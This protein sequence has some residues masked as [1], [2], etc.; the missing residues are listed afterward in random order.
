MPSLPGLDWTGLRARFDTRALQAY[1]LAA[2]APAAPVQQAWPALHAWCLAAPALRFALAV[3]ALH[4]AAE[5]PAR[6]R[7]LALQ[8]DGSHALRACSSAAARWR[9]RLRVKWQDLQGG[10]E[11]AGLVPVLP[12]SRIWDSG[13]ARGDA[14]ALAA[15]LPRRPSFVVVDEGP[16]QAMLQALAGLQARAAGFRHP[17]RVL[18]LLP[19]P[20]PP[21]AVLVAGC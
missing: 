19:G 3:P 8:L 13:R 2:N 7:S 20:V 1:V 10:D 14:L 6:A 12:A 17:V 15:L 5:A 4:A 11:A 16:P 9:L 21:Q 18:W